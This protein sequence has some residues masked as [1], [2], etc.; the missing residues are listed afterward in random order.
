MPKVHV[1]NLLSSLDP[2]SL[3][4]MDG[5]KLLN[6]VDR[7]YVIPASSL[8]A[9]FN[10]LRSQYSIL[11]ID[12]RRAFSYVTTYF[13]TSDYRF[14]KDH[15]NRVSSRI[16]V[17]SRTYKE[18]N[19]HFFEIKMKSNCRTDKYREVLKGECFTLSDKQCEKIKAI[20]QKNLSSPLIPALLNTYTRITLVNKARTERCTIDVDLAFQDPEVRGA[21]F[22]VDGIAI[23]ELKQSKTDISDGIAASLR[24][25]HIFPSSISKYILGIIHTHPEIKHNTFKPLL[26]KI[27]KI[28]QQ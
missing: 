6:R 22:N 21:E 15:H 12:V 2:I 16:K 1:Q 13:D 23:I 18:S 5:V 28:Q 4:E 10:L 8:P 19:L 20:Y 14:Y 11:D 9:I 17:R 24:K 26:H 25:R 7:K 3:T 27:E